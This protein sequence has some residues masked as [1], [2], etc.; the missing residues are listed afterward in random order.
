L[1]IIGRYAGMSVLTPEDIFSV[2]KPYL[3]ISR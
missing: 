2:S 3:G 1:D